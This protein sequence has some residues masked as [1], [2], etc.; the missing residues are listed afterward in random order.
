M[1]PGVLALRSKLRCP[2]PKKKKK[3]KK[4]IGNSKR[5]SEQEEI[6]EVKKN[7]VG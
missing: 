6:Q 1:C 4:I 7:K 5:I 2:C 3:N